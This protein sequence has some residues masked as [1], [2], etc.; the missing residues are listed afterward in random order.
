[1]TKSQ[2]D[3]E[4]IDTFAERQGVSYWARRKWRQRNHVPHK[5]RWGLIMGSDGRIN[6]KHF[7]QLD[8]QNRGETA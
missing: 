4:L 2:I 6:I 5:W 3:W 7:D 8:S 1:M